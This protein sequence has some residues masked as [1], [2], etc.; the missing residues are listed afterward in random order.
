MIRSGGAPVSGAPLERSYARANP[1]PLRLAKR[2]RPR[3][4]RPHKV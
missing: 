4:V 3:E 1:R 2:T